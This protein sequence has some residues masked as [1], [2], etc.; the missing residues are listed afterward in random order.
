M[1]YRVSGAFTVCCVFNLFVRLTSLQVQQWYMHYMYKENKFSS[2]QNCRDEIIR[3]S[4]PTAKRPVHPLKPSSVQVA[5]VVL[6]GRR[7]I[8][9]SSRAPVAEH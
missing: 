8:M 1:N 4:T 9:Y 7:N 5:T 2:Y 6:R 3:T